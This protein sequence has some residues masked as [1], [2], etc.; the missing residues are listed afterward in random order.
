MGGHRPGQLIRYTNGIGGEVKINYRSSTRYH[1]DSRRAGRPW[2]TSL[3]FPV[4]CVASVTSKDEVSRTASTSR[5]KYHNGYYDPVERQFR[6]FQMIDQWDT[7][8]FAVGSSSSFSR[9]PVHTRSWFYIGLDR[10]DEPAVLPGSWTHPLHVQTPETRT[11]IHAKP[12]SKEL[13]TKEVRQTYQSLAGRIRRQEVFSHDASALDA[14]PYQI[15]H[16]TYNVVMRQ[17][18]NSSPSYA[19][20]RVSDRESLIWHCDLR[21]GEL[22]YSTRS[23]WRAMILAMSV[24]RQMSI[25]A[26]AVAVSKKKTGNDSRRPS[27]Y[28]R[29][30]TTQT[31]S[32]F[33]SPQAPTTSRLLSRRT[34]ASI[35]CFPGPAGLPLLDI[36]GRR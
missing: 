33:H 28:M 14:V 16:R 22:D 35:A 34:C 13:T 29:K 25:M 11:D 6:G 36:L 9:Q 24:S 23:C 15:K 8:D 19:V 17:G 20:F 7:E 10:L 31:P 2:T 18:A 21:G 32:I 30:P 1:R 4:S 26:N 5:Y 27:F 12:V 3:P